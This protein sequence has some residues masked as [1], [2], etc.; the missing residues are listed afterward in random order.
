MRVEVRGRYLDG[1]AYQH[2]IEAFLSSEGFEVS[3][4]IENPTVFLAL[5]WSREVEA[6]AC[7]LKGTGTY[8]VFVCHEP[9]VVLPRGHAS[10]FQDLF[11]HLIYLGYPARNG[12]EEWPTP[13]HFPNPP[14]R[15]E[16]KESRAMRVAIINRN[17]FSVARGELYSLRRFASR[18]PKVDTFGHGWD[19][20][21]LTKIKQ[22][23]SS[24]RLCAESRVPL[25][26]G[27]ISHLLPPANFKGESADKRRTLEQYHATL[28]IENSIEYT[29]EKLLEPIIFGCIPIYV[30]SSHIVET[31]PGGLVIRS[32]T[33]QESLTDAIE[34][35]LNVN[36]E[37]WMKLRWE[38][39]NS[40]RA[41]Q[42][43]GESTYPRLADLI[44]H[45]D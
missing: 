11:D 9:S 15:I 32:T 23:L 42:L 13:F 16:L 28:A 26:P 21:K 36:L 1:L 33:S 4:R 35:A 7:E 22:C 34:Q 44:R 5:D 30:G 37:D 39:L 19:S 24:L 3:R 20:T 43:S 27:G 29:S 14:E 6:R 38:F 18:H 8:R 12:L 45:R 10:A 31:L 40:R 25:S 2:P 17:L 41:I